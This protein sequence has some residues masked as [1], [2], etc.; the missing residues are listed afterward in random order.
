MLNKAYW[1]VAANPLEKRFAW[2]EAFKHNS[3][4]QKAAKAS[5][6]VFHSA[7]RQYIQRV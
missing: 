4:C 1:Y 7:L 6:F 2:K 3:F 5:S